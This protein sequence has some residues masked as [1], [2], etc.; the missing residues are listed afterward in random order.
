MTVP[1]EQNKKLTVIY[2]LEPG[3]LGPQGLNHIDHFCYFAQEKVQ[4]IDSDIIIWKVLPRND[5]LLPEM[6]YKL[7]NKKL[8]RE[9]TDRFLNIFDKQIETFEESSHEEIAELIEMYFENN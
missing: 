1:L 7:N 6:E 4:S 9:K 5:K 8:S 2:R 3:C